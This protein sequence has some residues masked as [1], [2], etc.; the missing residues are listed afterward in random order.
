MHT[1]THTSPPA[2]TCHTYTHLPTPSYTRAHLGMPKHTCT[3][4]RMTF[5]TGVTCW[6]QSLKKM[7]RKEEER[8][9]EKVGVRIC[10]IHQQIKKVIW[11]YPFVKFIWSRITDLVAKPKINFPK[12]SA[13][14]KYSCLRRQLNEVPGL[15]WSSLISIQIFTYPD[16]PIPDIGSLGIIQICTEIAFT[17]PLLPAKASQCEERLDSFQI[18][19]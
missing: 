16:H 14:P 2:H 1:H 7:T 4:P 11:K 19:F 5:V 10:W 9:K 17:L 18:P 13:R 8:K 3:H 6:K 12:D 15:L